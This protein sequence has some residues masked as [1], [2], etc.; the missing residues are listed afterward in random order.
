MA[1]NFAAANMAGYNNPQIEIVTLKLGPDGKP[2]GTIPTYETIHDIFRRGAIPFLA[3]TDSS[4]SMYMLLAP[5]QYT[6]EMIDFSVITLSG[7]TSKP[8]RFTSATLAKG[9]QPNIQV[10]D[11]GG[12]IK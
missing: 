9:T 1:I 7:E 3:F 8:L 4:R 5:I 12:S 11:F 10:I 6:G 2:A